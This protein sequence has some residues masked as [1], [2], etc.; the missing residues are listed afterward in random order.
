MNSGLIKTADEFEGVLK[1]F[2]SIESLSQEAKEASIEHARDILRNLRILASNKGDA[3]KR[4]VDDEAKPEIA[5][6]LLEVAKIMFALVA[7]I[8]K[9]NKDVFNDKEFSTLFENTKDTLGKAYYRV[10]SDI[11]AILIKQGRS[12]EAL[13]M[14]E[15][16]EAIVPQKLRAKEGQLPMVQV[17]GAIEDHL[18]VIQRLANKKASELQVKQALGVKSKEQDVQAVRNN[19]SGVYRI[20][21]IN[22]E[23]LIAPAQKINEELETTVVYNNV[24]EINVEKFVPAA[25]KAN[26][27]PEPTFGQNPLDKQKI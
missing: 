15:Q 2:N 19:I 4:D 27:K 7:K 26:E 11:I 24:K 10:R 18:A 6:K 20:K 12:P 14:K 3:E 16:L 23:H 8:A 22:S 21:G 5:E 13:K 9:D 17:I 25:Q 1:T